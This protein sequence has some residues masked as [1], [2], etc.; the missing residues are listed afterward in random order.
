M[1]RWKKN[2]LSLCGVGVLCL[3]H[4][5]LKQPQWIFQLISQ[6]R[7]GALFFVDTEDP[8]IAL[9]I[10]DSPQV[11]STK[12]ILEVLEHHNVQATFFVLTDKLLNDDTILQTLI[13]E[14]HELGHHM[15]ADESSIR[16]SPKDFKAKFRKAEKTLSAYGTISWFRP[17]MGWYNRRMLDFVEAQGY[18]LVLGSL[19]PYDTHMPSVQFAEW[20]VLSNLD[21]GDILVLHDGPNNRGARTAQLLDQLL[22]KVQQ[23]GYRVVTL[24]ELNTYRHENIDARK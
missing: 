21:P 6:I 13:S 4:L 18:Q 23:K 12:A 5:S 17:G 15:T 7:P 14:G 22:P 1:K 10:D 8:V 2:I 20:F 3:V 11:D 16:L 19:F 24:K 9:T